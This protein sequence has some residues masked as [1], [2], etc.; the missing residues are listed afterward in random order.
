[1]PGPGTFG[2]AGA[3][4]GG[5]ILAVTE[6]SIMASAPE[7]LASPQEVPAGPGPR[8]HWADNLRALVI[9]VVVVWHTATAYLAGAH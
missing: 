6:E 4:A 1:M 8:E 3:L 7:I 5:T 2:S 9:A